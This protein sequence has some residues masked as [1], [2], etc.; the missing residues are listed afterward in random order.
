MCGE[1]GVEGP[2]RYIDLKVLNKYIVF[3]I[4]FL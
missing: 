2:K 4:E 3:K 1:E